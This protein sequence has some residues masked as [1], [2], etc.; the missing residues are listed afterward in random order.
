[1][2]LHCALYFLQV[3][4]AGVHYIRLQNS[5]YCFVLPAGGEGVHYIQASKYSGSGY[6]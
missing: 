5:M 2:A 4:R 1:M 3:V 6:W